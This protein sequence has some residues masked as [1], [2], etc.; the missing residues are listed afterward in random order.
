MSDRIYKIVLVEDNPGDVMLVEESLR[1]ARVPFHMIHCETV[2][3]AVKTVSGYCM[4]DV[5][6]PDLILLDYNLP[7]GE[8][9]EVLDAARANPALAG[10][11]KA[12]ITSSL[13]PRDRENALRSGADCVINK[14]ADLDLFLGEVGSAI[15]KLLVLPKNSA[16]QREPG[17]FGIPRVQLD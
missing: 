16:D 9:H 4:G 1:A 12:V 7:G 8:A 17:A 2:N 6:T 11:R 14:P 15:L 13:S 3:V 5:N 10:T